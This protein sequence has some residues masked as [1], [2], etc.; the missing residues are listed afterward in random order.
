MTEPLQS[1]TS[2]PTGKL[3]GR[4]HAAGVH[5]GKLDVKYVLLKQVSVAVSP[6]NPAAQPTVQV[7]PVPTLVQFEVYTV[8]SGA[9]YDAQGTG[10][11]TGLA[12]VEVK[13]TEAADPTVQVICW[14]AEPLCKV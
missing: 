2:T 13:D 1:L 4:L 9:A 10:T 5:D 6:V 12:L 8:E 11:Q 3:A 7:P 14:D